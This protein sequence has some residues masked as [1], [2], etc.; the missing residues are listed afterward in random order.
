M[1]TFPYCVSKMLNESPI[2]I[3]G[4]VSQKV[5][6]EHTPKHSGSGRLGNTTGIG[7]SVKQRFGVKDTGYDVLVGGVL[8]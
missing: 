6:R 2:W 7:D 3:M 1:H 5:Q 8:I 4:D